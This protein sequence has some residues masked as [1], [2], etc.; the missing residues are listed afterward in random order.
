M[1]GEHGAEQFLV[2]R[3]VLRILTLD[4]RRLHEPAPLLAGVSTLQHLRAGLRTLD[5]ARQLV[6][7]VI[8]RDGRRQTLL[9]K[10]AFVEKRVNALPNGQPTAAMLLGYAFRTALL[11]GQMPSALKLPNLVFPAHGV[12][13]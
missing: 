1:D 8:V 7:V 2:H 11:L 9:L 6:V 12:S 13:L 5:V 10:G 3:L 4:E